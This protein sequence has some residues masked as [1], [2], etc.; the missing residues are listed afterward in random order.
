M[1]DIENNRKI[2]NDRDASPDERL[3]ALKKIYRMH[4]SGI[5]VMPKKTQFI[6]NHI[7]TIYSFS[8]Y[9]PTAAVYEAWKAGLST[10]GIMDHDSIGGAREFLAAGEILDLPVTVGCELRVGVEGTR[11]EGKRLNNPD[12]L[13]CAYVA[14]HGIPHQCFD[15]LEGLL[16]QMRDIRNV[17]N[18]KMCGRINDLCSEYGIKLSFE[19]DVIPISQYKNGGSITERHLLFALVSKLEANKSREEVIELTEKLISSDLKEDVKLKLSE[20]TDKLFR[21]DLLGILKSHMMEKVYVDADDE[22]LTVKDFLILSREIGAISAYAY[23]GDVTKS[24][25]GDKKAQKFEDDY[26]NLL[27]DVLDELGFDAV[28]YMPSRNTPEQLERVMRLC[29]EHRLFQICGE[30]INQ[31]RQSFICEALEKPEFR[32]LRKAAFAL[33]GHEFAAT[34][35]LSESMFSRTNRRRPLDMRI[36]FYSAYGG[37]K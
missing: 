14:L 18:K 36:D 7:H 8:P 28:T 23:L 4:L 24:P 12:Q 6:N 3:E 1:I 10:A 37:L 34:Q 16:A 9:T 30:D 32:H 2:I 26:L 33:I 15:D 25:T 31:P 27:F 13:S 29:R 21:Y 5:S 11:L 17:R 19:D 35:D 20:D 22:M